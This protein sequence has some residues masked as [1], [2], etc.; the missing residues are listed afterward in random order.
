M[1]AP[2]PCQPVTQPVA[3]K[4]AIRPRPADARPTPQIAALLAALLGALLVLPAGNARAGNTPA[5]NNLPINTPVTKTLPTPHAKFVQPSPTGKG[6]T[7][8]PAIAKLRA[9]TIAPP[10][11]KPGKTVV[12]N[13]STHARTILTKRILPP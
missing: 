8:R 10:V 9:Q 4:L 2:Y 1:S 5:A 3:R 7:E 6:K 13:R 11:Q 12:G